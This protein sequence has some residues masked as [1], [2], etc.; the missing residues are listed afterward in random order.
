LERAH[1]KAA[2]GIAIKQSNNRHQ[3]LY[4]YVDVGSWDNAKKAVGKPK[5]LGN[6]T[7][8][9]SIPETRARQPVLSAVSRSLLCGLE[10]DAGMVRVVLKVVQD[11]AFG[12]ATNAM[13]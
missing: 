6:D 4:C 5:G 9:C 10:N 3:F 1:L 8:D 12:S 11:L 2:S 13:P 7:L